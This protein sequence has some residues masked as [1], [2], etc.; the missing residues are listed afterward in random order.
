M[1]ATELVL[2]RHGQSTGNVAREVALA[3]G[4]EVIDIGQRDADVPLS[5]LGRE[6]SE[7]LGRWLGDLPADRRPSGAWC[8][9]YLRAQQTADI[10]L[11]AAGLDPPVLVDERLRDRELGVLDL[12]TAQ[13]V[14]TRFP[15]ERDRRRWLGKLYYRP[16]GGESWADVALRLR[17][18]LPHIVGDGGVRLVVCHDAVVMLVRYILEGWDE[19]ML[20]DTAAATDIANCSVTRLVRDDQ[21][22]WAADLFNFVDHVR[23]QT[24]VTA[25][26]DDH[27]THPA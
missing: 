22:R 21:G 18:V 15:Q 12:L 14:A 11:A 5:T 3:N 19:R 2:V 26:E 20:L 7:A 8:S 4:S 1:A 13:G 10:A 16:P 9:P 27:A 23:R 17:S 6:Q 24:A 25:D